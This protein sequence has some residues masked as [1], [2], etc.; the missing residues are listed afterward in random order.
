MT[1]G[2]GHSVIL[3]FTRAP[4]RVVSLVPS[5]TESLFDLGA[6]EALVGVTEFC[7]PPE[8]AR[9]DLTVIGGTKSVNVGGGHRL[10][11]GNRA[12]QSGR[13]HAPGGRVR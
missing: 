4:R 7:R 8:Q 11:A 12:R 2:N 5:M 9:P 3:S 6:G 10:E 13:K 1:E